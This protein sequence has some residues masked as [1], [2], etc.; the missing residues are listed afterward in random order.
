MVGE[1]VSSGVFG[2]LLYCAHIEQAW[3]NAACCCVQTRLVCELA[4]CFGEAINKSTNQLRADIKPN[5][6]LRP[7]RVEMRLKRNTGARLIGVAKVCHMID[8]D[9]Q[10]VKDN[11]FLCIEW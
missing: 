1:Q 8:T 3:K 6:E 2:L 4:A 7:L 10:I 5:A 9:E 11:S